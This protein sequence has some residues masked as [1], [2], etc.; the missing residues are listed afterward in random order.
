M[1]R[2]I[3]KSSARSLQFMKLHTK[4]PKFYSKKAP[5]RSTDVNAALNAKEEE[6]Q[7]QRRHTPSYSSSPGS[8]TAESLAELSLDMEYDGSGLSL[9]LAHSQHNPRTHQ[10]GGLNMEELTSPKAYAWNSSTSIQDCAIR[11]D[12]VGSKRVEVFLSN[13][14]YCR[15]LF[16]ARDKGHV[17]CTN[18]CIV[19]HKRFQGR[20]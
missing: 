15:D 8:E 6:E 14:F 12:P 17:F 20:G 7:T 18:E 19:M 11:G 10:F 2:R 5:V 16:P 3:L 1:P 9:L 13:C 4:R